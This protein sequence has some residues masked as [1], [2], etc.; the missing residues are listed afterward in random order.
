ML[1]KHFA[2]LVTPHQ[3]GFKITGHFW[4]PTK[5]SY[6]GWEGAHFKI[7]PHRREVKC[8][9][10]CPVMNTFILLGKYHD[11]YH[12]IRTLLSFLTSDPVYLRH[13]PPSLIHCRNSCFNKCVHQPLYFGTYSSTANTLRNSWFWD[14]LNSGN[15]CRSRQAGH[16]F[17]RHSA[18]KVVACCSV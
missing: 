5:T 16:P 1:F 9:V 4:L 14:L 18:Y 13:T 6:R 15:P 3:S 12:E 11:M 10:K 7:A 8:R 2:L 17:H